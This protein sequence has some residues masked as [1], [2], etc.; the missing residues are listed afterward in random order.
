V[1]L[2]SACGVAPS[3]PDQNI[4]RIACS[5]DAECPGDLICL[6]SAGHCALRGAVPPSLAVAVVTPDG[7][8]DVVLQPSIEVR[9]TGPVDPASLTGRLS[10]TAAADATASLAQPTVTGDAVTVEVAAPLLPEVT[11]TVEVAAGIEATNGLEP[12]LAPTVASFTTGPQ[13]PAA[14]GLEIDHATSERIE[15]TWTT[16]REWRA[17]SSS[18]APGNH[19]P[20]LPGTA[21]PTRSAMTSATAPS[22]A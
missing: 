9:F 6:E 13:P 15:I 22:S 5:S 4:E 19:S 12:S 1:L 21:R 7:T 17:S 10:L 8:V 20:K 16:P 3:V 18:A 2:V 11:Y 14:Q